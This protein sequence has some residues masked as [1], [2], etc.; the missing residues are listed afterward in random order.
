MND[1]QKDFVLAYFKEHSKGYSF[2]TLAE[3]LGVP[4]SVI[5]DC[6]AQLIGDDFLVYNSE[7]MLSLTAKGRLHILNKQAD[8]LTFEKTEIKHR[9]IRPEEA[10]PLDAIYI[11]EG[12][13]AKLK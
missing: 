1:F 8:F 2:C 7:K 5:D 4:I 3:S 6:I 11:P 12:F 13:I 10:L 9:I